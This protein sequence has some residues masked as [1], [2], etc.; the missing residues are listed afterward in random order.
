MKRYQS[1]VSDWMSSPPVVVSPTMTVAAAYALMRENEIRR[2][3]VVSE[4]GLQRE[5]ER[6]LTGIITESDILRAASGPIPDG[7]NERRLMQ[8]SLTVGDVMT[9]DPITVDPEDTIQEAAER[10]LEYQVSGLPVIS[11]GKVV[12]VITESD[13]F[14]LVVAEWSEE[15]EPAYDRNKGERAR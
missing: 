2:L 7:D 3:L 8:T 14:R 12:G 5:S 13:I 10:M 6:E 4:R 15:T 9:Y 1:Q 11:G